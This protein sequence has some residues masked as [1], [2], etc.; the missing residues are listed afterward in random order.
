MLKGL[1]PLPVMLIGQHNICSYA[2]VL[3]LL[4][5]PIIEYIES[6]CRG[7]SLEWTKSL[8]F[9]HAANLYEMIG[10][11]GPLGDT[12]AIDTIIDLIQKTLCRLLEVHAPTKLVKTVV[13]V[14]VPL[15]L[16]TTQQCFCTS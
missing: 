11:V 14:L 8:G 15:H 1:E 3:N 13:G 9:D 12:L 6:I 5:C 4:W 10:F 2:H 16:E 7:E